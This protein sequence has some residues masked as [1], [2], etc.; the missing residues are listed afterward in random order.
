MW[1]IPFQILLMRINYFCKLNCDFTTFL[2]QE[3][4]G[5][6]LVLNAGKI[7]PEFGWKQESPPAA[8]Q[9][10]TTHNI[11][12]PQEKPPSSPGVEEGVS[13]YYPGVGVPPV[14]TRVH[15]PVL[16]GEYPFGQDPETGQEAIPRDRTIVN[17]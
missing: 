12:R 1:D 15:H 3:I 16:S 4:Y 5:N 8:Q 2:L 9:E 17:R 10:T 14:L 11:S 7:L 13:L 6:P